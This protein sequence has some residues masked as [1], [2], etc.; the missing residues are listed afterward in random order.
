MPV[1]SGLVYEPQT[2]YQIEKTGVACIEIFELGRE[3]ELTATR[4]A[5]SFLVP[6]QF[7]GNKEKDRRDGPKGR[8]EAGALK[9]VDR[10]LDVPTK[11]LAV[12]F[13]IDYNPAD[14]WPRAQLWWSAQ[15]Y[16]DRP[17]WKEKYEELLKIVAQSSDE[18]RRV[19]NGVNGGGLM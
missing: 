11:R 14:V 16:V 19:L 9:L 2:V 12:I 1:P 17:R 4:L 8:Y 5:A 7:W 13:H 3:A 6:A 15:L 18:A 10:R